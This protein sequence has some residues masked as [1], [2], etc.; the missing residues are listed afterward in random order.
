M[1]PVRTVL[2]ALFGPAA[3]AEATRSASNSSFP[4]F[5]EFV[6]ENKRTYTKDSAEYKERQVHYQKR[7]GG[8]LIQ[9]ADAKRTWSA[10]ANH[11]WDWSDAEMNTLYG[12]RGHSGHQQSGGLALASAHTKEKFLGTKKADLPASKDWSHLTSMNPVRSQG[13]CGSCWA[14]AAAVVLENHAELNGNARSFS[15]QH[16]LNCMPNP[17]ECGGQ[18][19][20]RGATA[21]M[22][23]DWVMKNGCATET[24]VPY[25]AVDGTCTAVGANTTALSV[26]GSAFGMTGWQRLPENKYEDLLRAV[27][28]QGPVAVSVAAS[29][30][31][32]YGTGIF[33]GCSK[34]AIVNHAV[35]MSGY[36]VDGTMKFWKIQNSWGADWG[37]AG[38][39]RIVRH[40]DEGAW[41]GVDKEPE[42][43]SAC[44]P[45]PA[46]VPVC[47]SCGILY[48]SVL[49]S[50]QAVAAL[51]SK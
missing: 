4:T 40:E 25:Q 36:G 24:E 47:G 43:G 48:E 44:K 51:H 42:M 35:V 16:I 23:M 11:L 49:P 45:Y 37:E 17:K 29:E 21:V 1:A 13:G 9:N 27:A 33:N 10:R 28:E 50:F 34:D 6:Q 3:L 31:G 46:E 2:L 15:A 20:C 32:S 18:G 12:R 7:V 26:G 8:A 30:W 14:V 41:C 19:G 38:S 22:A 5:D 39:M